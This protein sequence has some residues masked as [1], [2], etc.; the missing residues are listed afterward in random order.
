MGNVR[1]V[2]QV[3]H[4]ASSRVLQCEQISNCAVLLLL[5]ATVATAAAAVCLR[6]DLKEKRSVLMWATAMADPSLVTNSANTNQP[7]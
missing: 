1:L 6:Y 5:A 7:T 3:A 2:V 4:F